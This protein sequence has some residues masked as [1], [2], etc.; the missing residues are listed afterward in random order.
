MS[1]NNNFFNSNFSYAGYAQGIFV[2]NDQ[3]KPYIRFNLSRKNNS[4]KAPKPF[5]SVPFVAF[6]EVARELI[7]SV[8]A[9]D[10]VEIHKSWVNNEDIRLDGEA[11]QTSKGFPIERVIFVVKEFVNKG[12]RR[13]NQGASG[14]G[15]SAPAPQQAAAP[16][17]QQAAP[18]QAAPAPQQAA[19]V[20]ASPQ[21]DDGYDDDIPF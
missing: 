12:G 10:F 2:G 6:G 19:P 3:T 17:H 21:Q 4:D 18:V 8:K 16:V 5:T 15:Q 11:I 9:N 1:E 7:N 13:D 20:Q 14:G